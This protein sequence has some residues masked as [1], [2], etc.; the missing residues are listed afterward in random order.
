[1]TPQERDLE[2]IHGGS[3]RAGELLLRDL[4]AIE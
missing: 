4:S 2:K 1:M 3:R